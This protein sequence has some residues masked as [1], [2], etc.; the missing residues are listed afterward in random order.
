M[1]KGYCSSLIIEPLKIPKKATKSLKW[2]KTDSVAFK[3]MAD[4]NK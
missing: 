3:K 2:L 4:Q 1:A